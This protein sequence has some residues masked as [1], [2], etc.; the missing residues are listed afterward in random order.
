METAAVVERLRRLGTDLADVEVK[1]AAGGL[2]KSIVETLSAFAN[3]NGGTVLLGLSEE[4][5]FRPAAGFNA[6]AIRDALAAACA[7]KLEPPLRIDVDV[8]AFEGASIVRADVPELDPLTKPCY[9]TTRGAYQ[10][11][12]IRSGDGDRALNHYEVTQLLLNRTQPT[13]DVEPVPDASLDDL[14]EDL[15]ARLVRRAKERQPRVFADL[16]ATATLEYLNVVT[17]VDGV[18]VPTLA[19]LLSLGT[20]PQQFF[21]QLFVSVVVLPTTTFGEQTD[22]GVRFVDNV[23]ADGPIPVMLAEATAAL[24][25]NMRSAAVVTGLFREDR[26]DYPVDVIRELLTNAL[27]HRD[28]SPESRGTQVQVELYPDRLEIRSPGGLYGAINADDLGTSRVSSSRNA[29]LARLLADVPAADGDGVV[30]EN[31]ASGLPKVTD[32]L[33]RAGMSPARFDVAPARVNVTV[34]QHALLAPDVLE[35]IAALGHEDLSD[36]Q[37]LAIAMMR[38]TGRVTNGMLQVWGVDRHAASNALTD[39]VGRGLAIKSGGK[40]YAS[41]RLDAIRPARGTVVDGARATPGVEAELDALIQAIRSGHGTIRAL[42]L[43]VGMPEHTTRRRINMLIER[44]IVE[45]S[46][47]PR[48]SRQSYR[49]TDGAVPS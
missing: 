14:D 4:D 41:Y 42:A 37:R 48:S 36:A 28:Y 2:P 6:T 24:Q 12:F 1:A 26:Y 29:A 5:G 39:L 13:F 19:G 49:L 9:V 35:W 20:Y 32:S 7:D 47:P 10:G 34:P 21:P 15:V 30:S 22:T 17:R 25:R 18:A 46:R 3:G 31:R 45:R 8:E 23:S 40:R 38:S 43:A 27:M 11:S 33:R 16:D 44:G